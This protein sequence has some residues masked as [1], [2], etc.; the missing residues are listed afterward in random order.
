LKKIKIKPKHSKDI[1]QTI[2]ENIFSQ[3]YVDQWPV[4]DKNNPYFFI[5][6]KTKASKKFKP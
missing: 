2:F 5:L 3:F 4:K 6:I 1:G